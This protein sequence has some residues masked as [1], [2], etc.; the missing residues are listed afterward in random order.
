MTSRW[1]SQT[2]DKFIYIGTDDGFIHRINIF[3]GEVEWSVGTGGPMF[4][5]K[6]QSTTTFFPSMDGFLVSFTPKYGYRR[7]PIPIRD[8]VFLAPFVAETGQI[9]TSGKSTKIYFVDIFL[10]TLHIVKNQIYSGIS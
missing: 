7:F 1:T 10:Y 3:K 9:F 4:D 8:L 6:Y 5:S 2:N